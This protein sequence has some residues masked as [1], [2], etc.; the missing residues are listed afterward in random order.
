M[1]DSIFSTYSTGEN[2]VTASILAVLRSLSL[3]RC[4]Q[5][6]A[7][8]VGQSEFELIRFQNQPSKGSEG[9]PDAEIVSS[10]RF[11]IETKIRSNAVNVSQL[12]RHL[13]RFDGSSE[14]TRIL[15]VLT[16]DATQPPQIDEIGDRRVAWASFASLDQAIDELFEDK[17]EVI[18][19]REAF[20][21]RQLQTMLDNEGLIGT[22]KN[23]LVIPAK[24][25]WPEYKQFK[26]YVCQ[27]NRSFKPVAY[28]AFYHGNEI[29][30]L[31]PKILDS[32]EC[33]EMK[34]GLH[35]GKL[36]E[37]VNYLLEN[38]LRDEGKTYKVLFLSH[39]DAPETIR[40]DR[41]IINDL[42]AATGRV[43]A[44]TQNQRYVELE[45]LKK[46]HKT[47]EL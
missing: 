13:K 23:V 43:T 44:F 31:I 33:V 18:S 40:L 41:P 8:L 22:L 25:A 21:L 17:E 28:L 29:H 3:T 39:P 42:V 6:L 10:C 24:N 2:R 16:P 37:L 19:E 36:G 30:E 15:L 5:I 1:G 14:T 47:S 46:A 35:K 11:L 4:E 12:R 9:I 27:A 26:S 20:L 45:A 7:A 38:R 32:F 34:K